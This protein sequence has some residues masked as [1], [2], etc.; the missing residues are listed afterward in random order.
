MDWPPFAMK[1]KCAEEAVPGGGPW[2]HSL[3]GWVQ[4]VSRY[5]LFVLFTECTRRSQSGEHS[6]EV[7][8]PEEV[9]DVLLGL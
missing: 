7:I 1:K 2:M 5:M 4:C 8:G 3:G 9:G 6:E